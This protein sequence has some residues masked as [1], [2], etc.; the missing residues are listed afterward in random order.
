MVDDQY[1]YTLT[2]RA[3]VS[4]FTGLG[5][6]GLVDRTVVRKADNLPY[7]PGST[8]KGRLRFFAERLLR[9]SPPQ[10]FILHEPDQ[11]HCKA[12]A[13]ACT[14]CRLFGNPAM[15]AMLRV[16]QAMPAPPWDTLFLELLTADHNP[17]LRPDVEIRPGIALS[18]SRRTALPDH[19]F[20]D[21]TV[22][23]IT[24][25][26]SM[27]LEASVNPDERLFLIGTG[28]LVDALGARKSAGRGALEGGVQIR[29]C[30]KP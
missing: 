5:I 7:I 13:T 8:V 25:S 24:F 26:G 20:F 10:G 28:R 11:P 22:P 2:F 6:A 9:S 15:P 21:E 29:E 4:I 16:G 1:T 23:A 30:N 27:L 18:R 19:L 17:V 12:L 3:P 14:I